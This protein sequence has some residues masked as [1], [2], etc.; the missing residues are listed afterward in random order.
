M[1]FFRTKAQWLIPPVRGVNPPIILLLLLGKA[2]WRRPWMRKITAWSLALSLNPLA[3]PAWCF[4]VS[5][6]LFTAPTNSNPRARETVGHPC[7]KVWI[8]R[9]RG[10]PSSGFRWAAGEEVGSRWYSSDTAACYEALW[11]AC[12]PIILH[13]CTGSDVEPRFVL[14]TRSTE[15]N[16]GV[17]K[18]GRMEGWRMR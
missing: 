3:V 12:T 13:C 10:N 8:Q 11:F 1:L 7:R 4:P 5:F 17:R 2:G 18:R 14:W 9:R 16:S 15:K 6:F